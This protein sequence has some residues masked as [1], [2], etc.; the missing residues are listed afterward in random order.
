MARRVR[1]VGGDCNMRMV[2]NVLW[3]GMQLCIESYSP[4]RKMGARNK[5]VRITTVESYYSRN[6][7]AKGKQ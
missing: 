6:E 7:K 4:G 1:R 5:E 3:S 2:R